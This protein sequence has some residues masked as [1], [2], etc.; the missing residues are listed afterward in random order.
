MQNLNMKSNLQILDN[1]G[2]KVE[3]SLYK[4]TVTVTTDDEREIICQSY[5]QYKTIDE[6]IMECIDEALVIFNKEELL[7][8]LSKVLEIP[9][10]EFID[11]YYDVCDGN[12]A[13]SI[14]LAIFYSKNKDERKQENFF[15]MLKTATKRK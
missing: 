13:N 9:T 2:Y 14:L 12:I 15:N 6:C 11:V 5:N 10:N 3:V 4:E 7:R 8:S 1:I